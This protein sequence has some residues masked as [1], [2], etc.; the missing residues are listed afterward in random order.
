MNIDILKTHIHNNNYNLDFETDGIGMTWGVSYVRLA[1]GQKSKFENIEHFFYS[2][3][4][5]NKNM[6]SGIYGSPT[7]E[8]RTTIKEWASKLKITD[9]KKEDLTQF[10]ESSIKGINE[11]LQHWSTENT[12]NM[13]CLDSSKKYENCF[14]I[15]ET[16][17]PR[18]YIN[19][20]DT[21]LTNDESYYYYI[22]GHWES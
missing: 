12:I 1:I 10:I 15:N 20:T 6:T 17:S 4:K 2:T 19:S 7:W 5:S 22:E 3:L 11:N 14:L 18:H 13:R 21:Y 16:I 8:Q 9:I